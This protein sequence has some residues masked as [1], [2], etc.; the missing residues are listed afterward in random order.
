MK[1]HM[2]ESELKKLAGLNFNFEQMQKSIDQLKK[3]VD[4]LASN[5]KVK[6]GTTLD[7]TV[8]NST[9]EPMDLNRIL[10]VPF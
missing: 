5:D 1:F 7:E 3:D 8:S 10:E 2:P 6:G 4:K 9:T